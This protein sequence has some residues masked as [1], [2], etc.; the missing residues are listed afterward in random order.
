MTNSSTLTDV[1][2][3]SVKIDG[4]RAMVVA[5]IHFDTGEARYGDQTLLVRED[6]VWKVNAR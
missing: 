4:D 6:G 2:I 3:K 1:D 5:D